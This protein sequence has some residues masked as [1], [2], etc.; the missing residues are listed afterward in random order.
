[1]SNPYEAGG[2]SYDVTNMQLAEQ[3]LND[4]YDRISQIK[5]QLDTA[6]NNMLAK[7]QGTAARQFGGVV[8]KFNA[9]LQDIL[10]AQTELA[11]QMGMA[12]MEHENNSQQQEDMVNTFAS[13]LNNP[14]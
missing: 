10:N 3:R 11:S 14:K 12:K 5:L 13:L 1:M 4:S 8:D 9:N 2:K 7:W 6:K